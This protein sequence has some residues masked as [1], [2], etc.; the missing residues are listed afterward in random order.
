MAT[1]KNVRDVTMRLGVETAGGDD[2]KKL[3]DQFRDLAKAGGDA[4]PAFERQAAALDAAGAATDRARAAERQLQTATTAT[5]VSIQAKRDALKLS[6]IETDAATKKTAAFKAETTAAKV[7][8]LEQEKAL[9]TQRDALKQSRAEAKAA[10]VAQKAL[11]TE[12]RATLAAVRKGSGDAGDNLKTVTKNAGEAGA[13]LARLGPLIAGAFGAQQFVQTIAT[14]ESLNRGFEQIFGSAAKGRSEMEFVRGTA[15]KL[16]IEVQVL[17]RNYQSLAASTR[18]TTLEGQATRDV[19]EAVARAMSTLGKSSPEAERALVAIAQMASK[20]VVSMEEMRQQL[21]EALPGAMQAAADGAGLTD[22]QLTALIGSG[23]A[24]A[25][26]VLPALTKGLNDLYGKAA[27][28]QNIVSEWARLKNVITDTMVAIGE[29]GASKGIAKTLSGVAIGVQGVSG[30]VDV[31]GVAIGEFV[32]KLETGNHELGTAAALNEKYDA[33]LRKSAEAAGLVDKAQAGAIQATQAQ[34]RAVDNAAA[35]QERGTTA[36]NA[37][38]ESAL[39][40]KARYAEITLQAGKYTDLLKLQATAKQAESS[41]VQQ[42]V[43][44]YGSEV[45]KRQAAGAAAA[46]QATSSRDLARALEA[47]AIIAQSLALKLQE[48]A[49]RRNDTSEATRKEIQ[50]AMQSA[51]AKRAEADQSRAVAVSKGIE[52]EAT[53]ASAAAYADNAARVYELR[54]AAGAAALEVERLTAA[55][56]IGK[57]TDEQ[58]ADARAKASAAT[59]LYRDALRDATE[60]ADR[61]IVKEQQAARTVQAGIEVEIARAD[62]M[63]DV[64]AANGDATASA[65]HQQRATAL[66]AEAADAAAAAAR[67]EAQAIRE[68][69]D[70]RESELRTTGELTTARQAEIEA[71]RKSADLKDLEAQRS[72]ILAD[73]TRSLAASEESRTRVLEA[74]I[75]A[76]EKRLDLMERQDALERKRRGVDKSGFA[77]DKDGNRIVAGGD[78]NTRTGI[79]AFLKSMGVDDEATAKRI[80]NEFADARGDV[81]YQG[82]AGQN[83]YGGPGSTISQALVKAA[84]SVTFGKGQQGKTAAGVAPPAPVAESAASAGGTSHTVNIQLPGG[85]GGT[86]NMASAGDASGLSGLLSQLGNARKVN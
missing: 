36:N 27:P 51:A 65:A 63:R 69:A 58:V 74:Q 47:E 24:L 14:Q 53:K 17:A 73:K 35:A 68:A 80:T 59:L 37:G 5:K 19:F 28:P 54:G 52:V 50:N 31:A 41:A 22:G 11:A 1:G 18:G 34:A 61:R 21:G 30:A 67:R 40:L 15:N 48:E 4:A 64:A 43:N 9:R 26:D 77:A 10:A 75:T 85:Q 78:L 20:G 3:S 7:A 13:L 49:A 39:A 84:E 46:V 38:A 12:A 16:G 57:A 32:A 25:A 45:E 72:D 60:A 66:Q 62:A 29:G 76:E 83:K 56:K 33:A 23:N 44:V 6:G 42:L 55:Q 81:S 8:L 82:S 79:L 2:V 86:F 71:M 70:A